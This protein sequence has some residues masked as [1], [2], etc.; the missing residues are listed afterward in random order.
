[1]T[2]SECAATVSCTAL[3][4]VLHSRSLPDQA[5]VASTAP[6][7]EKEQAATGRPSPTSLVWF[8]TC[9]RPPCLPEPCVLCTQ[10]DRKALCRPAC[11]LGGPVT[12][13]AHRRDGLRPRHS[14]LRAG[15]LRQGCS[16][17]PPLVP[18]RPPRAR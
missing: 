17:Q 9:A 7:G 2:L 12:T 11:S 5:P 8:A 10:I 15:R 18:P 4:A 3:S 6:S 1:M 13:A 16:K 14:E